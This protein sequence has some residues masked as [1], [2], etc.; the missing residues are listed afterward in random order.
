[1]ARSLQVAAQARTFREGRVPK[2]FPLLFVI[3]AKLN[4]DNGY[5]DLPDRR[6][7]RDT[8]SGSAT[9]TYCAGDFSG[10]SVSGD[11]GDFGGADAGG[12]GG[13]GDGCGGGGD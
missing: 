4:I 2:R 6:D 8:A 3:D 10:A 9:A 1:M 12:G 11:V 13:E 7:I 5:H